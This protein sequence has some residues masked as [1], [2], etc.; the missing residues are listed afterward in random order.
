MISDVN[1]AALNETI[2]AYSF[3]VYM[4]IINP[5][6]YTLE[7]FKID[8]VNIFNILYK[9]YISSIDSSKIK[10]LIYRD[11]LVLNNFGILPDTQESV[12]E[13]K[14]AMRS[15]D[16]NKRRFLKLVKKGDILI[17]GR[18]MVGWF[19]GH[20][21]IMT[22]DNMVLEMAGGVGCWKNGI[23]SNNR[24]IAKDKWYDEH[25][26]DW[27]T[28]YR[29]ADEA[30]AREAATWA[31]LTFYNSADEIMKSKHITYAI[32]TDVWKVNPSY[33][34]KLVIHAYYYGTGKRNVI[35]EL[36]MLGKLIVPTVIPWYFQSPYK[37]ENK[38]KF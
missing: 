27:T 26:V 9:E 2:A 31:N 14:T 1:D 17:T 25:A 21:A 10:P 37:L 12:V 3:G 34:S 4:G 15:T 19:V 35:K 8:E 16:A 22:S 13:K 32:T 23:I 11:W 18:G 30:V 20:A 33:C 28:V 38:G 24:Q 7:S 36:T 29:C 6:K 5:N